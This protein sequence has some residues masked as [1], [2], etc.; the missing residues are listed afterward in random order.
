MGLLSV[1]RKSSKLV[2]CVLEII[3]HSID[4]FPISWDY[5]SGS[6]VPVSTSR[7]DVSLYVLKF[8]SFILLPNFFSPSR[9]ALICYVS[10]TLITSPC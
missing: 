5:I 10:K 3:C 2:N 4:T 7:T 6:H 9:D 8:L 1:V